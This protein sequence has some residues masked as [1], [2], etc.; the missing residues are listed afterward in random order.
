[1]VSNDQTSEP[2]RCVVA[3]CCH[4]LQGWSA[5]TPGHTRGAFC[6]PSQL[7]SVQTAMLHGQLPKAVAGL[8]SAT[9]VPQVDVQ[10]PHILPSEASPL[11]QIHGVSAGDATGLSST[12]HAILS[13][14]LVRCGSGVQNLHS[15]CWRRLGLVKGL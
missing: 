11:R 9:S 3:G 1:M 10:G 12:Q 7:S 5:L 8:P 2:G 13:C 15:A 14:A 6:A 4:L